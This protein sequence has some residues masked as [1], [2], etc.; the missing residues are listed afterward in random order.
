MSTKGIKL[1]NETARKRSGEWRKTP[2]YCEIN[3]WKRRRSISM[4][5]LGL[6]CDVAVSGKAESPE[7]GID[8]TDM[9]KFQNTPRI[10]RV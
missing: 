6:R 5:G 3:F 4:S 2:Y 10:R 8:F 7:I 9:R 1:P